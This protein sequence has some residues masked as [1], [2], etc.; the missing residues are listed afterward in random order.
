MRIRDW[1]SDVCSSDLLADRD[2]D[3]VRAWIAKDEGLQA[4]PAQRLFAHVL[5]SQAECFADTAFSFLMADANRLHIGNFEDQSRPAKRL[6]TA[7]SPYWSAAQLRAFE[8][9]VLD[10]GDRKSGVWGT[11]WSV[12]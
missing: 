2:P 6:I 11:S 4:A 7:A 9:H 3:A 8:Q 10:R 12:L 5:A 1:S